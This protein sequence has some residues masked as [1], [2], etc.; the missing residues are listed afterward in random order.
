MFGYSIVKTRRLRELETREQECAYYRRLSQELQAVNEQLRR[1]ART[2]C[3][4]REAA[5]PRAS[6]ARTPPFG[7]PRRDAFPLP[8]V[9]RQQAPD[10]L[11]DSGPRLFA[12]PSSDSCSAT[13]ASSSSS[14]SSSCSSGD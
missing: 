4:V 9:V 14:D 5:G 7:G 11:W 8:R 3:A 10:A 6:V 12:E 1:D 2:S 13:D